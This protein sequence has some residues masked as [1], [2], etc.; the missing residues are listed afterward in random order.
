MAG[1]TQSRGVWWNETADRLWHPA[2]TVRTL[3]QGSPS[4]AVITPGRRGASECAAAL[5]GHHPFSRKRIMPRH[6]DSCGNATPR[7]ALRVGRD[8]ESRA[9]LGAGTRS[10]ADERR[11]LTVW[12]CT[13]F[14]FGSPPSPR[15]D[16]IDTGWGAPRHPWR[17]HSAARGRTGFGGG[18]AAEDFEGGSISDLQAFLRASVPSRLPK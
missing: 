12:S 16:S 4:E 14:G 5:P 9:F 17:G 10:F 15:A 3:V 2:P 8:G 1:C 13:G 18:A 6:S 7:E 11:P